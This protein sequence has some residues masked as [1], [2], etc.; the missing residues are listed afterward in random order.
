[1]PL[2]PSIYPACHDQLREATAVRAAGQRCPYASV[3]LEWTYV[4]H[5]G[6]LGYATT[7]WVP[8]DGEVISVT[9]AY[10]LSA[11]L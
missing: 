5:A 9:P 11:A 7:A 10:S 4:E 6:A 3:N 2:S 1:M 8:A